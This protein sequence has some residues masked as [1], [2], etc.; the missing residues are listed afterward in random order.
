[1]LIK[2]GIK[3]RRYIEVVKCWLEKSIEHGAKEI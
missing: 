3:E 1:M 2:L